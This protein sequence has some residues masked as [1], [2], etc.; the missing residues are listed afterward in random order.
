MRSRE[1][2]AGD[3][4]HEESQDD[5]HIKDIQQAAQYFKE[6]LVQVIGCDVANTIHAA[7]I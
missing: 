5:M 7:K 2:I 1:Q 3:Q 6:I 4:G